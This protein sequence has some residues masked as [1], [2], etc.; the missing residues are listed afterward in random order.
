[1]FGSSSGFFLDDDGLVLN[2]GRKFFEGVCY[3]FKKGGKF[4][5][6]MGGM[7]NIVEVRVVMM[8]VVVRML[9]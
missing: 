9:K 2:R 3:V 4:V 5:F 7:G 6:E 1:M 8:G